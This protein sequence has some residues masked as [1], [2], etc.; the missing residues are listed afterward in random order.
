MAFGE[1]EFPNDLTRGAFHFEDPRFVS[2][3]PHARSDQDIAVAQA[4][5]VTPVGRVPVV[6]VP[7]VDGE[8]ARELPHAFR[9]HVL[10]GLRR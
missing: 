1:L 5:G 6:G 2:R 7:I 9:N 10:G 3:Q 8:L 4:V